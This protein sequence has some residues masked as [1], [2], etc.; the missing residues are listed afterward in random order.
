MQKTIFRALV[1]AAIL[2]TAPLSQGAFAADGETIK[3]GV[4]EP[5]SGSLA[6]AGTDLAN[7]AKLAAEDINA[8]GGVL[9]K[10]V[11]VIVIDDA[12]DAQQGVQVTEKLINLGVVG[13][14]G[15]FCSGSSIPESAVA[16]RRDNMP[17]LAPAA[18]NPKLTEQGYTNVYRLNSRDDAEAPADVAYMKDILGAKK[19]AILNDNA[20]YSKGVTTLVKAN[21]EKAGLDV[22]F[23][24]AITPGAS[25]YTSTLT[26]IAGLQ[27]DVLYYGGYYTEFAQLIKQWK[28]LDLP[29]NLMGGGGTWDP[30]LLETAAGVIEDPKVSMTNA[31]LG[32]FSPGTAKI[33]EQYKAKFGVEPGAYAVFE[34]DAVAILAAAISAAG[35]TDVGAINKALH[36]ISY[37]GLTGTIKFDEKGDRGAFPYIQV[38]VKGGRFIKLADYNGT[39]WKKK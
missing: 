33:S 15:G 6:S 8:R 36:E 4:P 19:I 20:T 17:F 30:V 11:E 27:P 34:Y 14:A 2:M 26:R 31:P 18:S 16:R 22:V 38:G 13:I 9:G 10:Q 3:I 39:S 7:A 32:E 29:F 21:A 37:S 23:F 1:G 25:D 12:C 5:L 24:D 35:S 28:S